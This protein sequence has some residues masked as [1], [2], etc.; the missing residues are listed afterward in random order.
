MFSQPVQVFTIQIITG[1]VVKETIRVGEAE[2]RLREVRLY[3]IIVKLVHK[4][5]RQFKD[6]ETN[7]D[8]LVQCDGRLCKLHPHKILVKNF[9]S[10]ICGF[11]GLPGVTPPTVDKY[12]LHPVPHVLHRLS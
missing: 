12:D 11:G 10:F 1:N 2:H 5:F 4:Q 8:R 7:I 6:S 9:K 3:Y